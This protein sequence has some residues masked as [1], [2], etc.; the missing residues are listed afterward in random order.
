MFREEV[1]ASITYS[2]TSGWVCH[3]QFLLA[4]TSVFILG[5]KSCG[6]H[7]HI[8]LPQIRD[9]F[10]SPHTTRSA[11]VEVFDPAS[12]RAEAEAYHRQRAGTLTLGIAPRWD[13]RPCICSMSRPL[14]FFSFRWSSLL[15]KEGVGL[16]YIYI[17]WCSLT[18]P[19][20]T[21]G[22]IFFSQGF[23]RI[24]INWIHY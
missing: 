22:Y 10:S 21:W 2:L 24:Y 13:P 7:D 17:D 9:F 15:I 5:S 8:L 23:S 11:T 12:T 1:T 14:F 19:Y 20:S 3:L 16:F 18:T 6:T 4:L